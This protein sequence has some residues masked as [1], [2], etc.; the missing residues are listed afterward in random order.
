MQLLCLVDPSM[1]PFWVGMQV[2]LTGNHGEFAFEWSSRIKIKIRG[3][4]GLFFK[5]EQNEAKE[6]KACLLFKSKGI[7][8]LFKELMSSLYK[9]VYSI[10][11]RVACCLPC[12]YGCVNF[13]FFKLFMQT[14]SLCNLLF[15]LLIFM[16]RFSWS[17]LKLCSATSNPFFFDLR[18]C[19][20]RQAFLSLFFVP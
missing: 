20:V 14:P 5:G 6:I 13:E 18:S 9:S 7:A 8:R 4:R 3:G 16:S 10:S 12:V 19:F 17:A 11:Q 15:L 1:S 2:P